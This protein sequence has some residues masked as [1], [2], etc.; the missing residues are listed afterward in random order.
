[1]A[2]KYDDRR[3][4]VKTWNVLMTFDVNKVRNDFPLLKKNE[5][6]VY[7]DNASTTQKP[8]IVLKAY[9]DYYTKYNANVHR[10]MYKI[11][12][13][14]TAEFELSRKIIAD[15][16]GAKSENSIIFTSGATASINTVVQG[17]GKRNL[18]SGDRVL[19][20][21]MEHH[22]NIVPWQML[23]SSLGIEIDYMPVDEEGQLDLSK[24]DNLITEKTK[25][26]SIIHQS[27][28]LGTVNPIKEIID[29]GHQRGC[30]VLIDGAQSIAHQ[31]IDVEE[32]GCDFFVFSGHKIYGPTGIGV[33]YGSMEKL[34]DMD[35]FMGGGEMISTVSKDGFIPNE[36]PWR[37]EAGTPAIA[38]VITLKVAIDYIK[39]IGI[40]NIAEYEND[41][42][43][44]TTTKILGIDG[45]ET[46]A[47][48][49]IDKGPVVSFNVKGVHPYDLTQI[50]DQMGVAIR[51]GHH[52][53]QPLMNIFGVEAMNRI[54]LSFYNTKDEIDYL[55]DS[56]KKSIAIIH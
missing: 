43:E 40:K 28:V 44:Y 29:K 6:L 54:S 51:S 37:F 42:L 30:V 50:L 5:K 39:S 21:E 8:D 16:I 19:L 3:C 35:P 41:L 36:I 45:I 53:A 22:S 27:N 32:L 24:I 49:D 38:E 56:I 4:E 12:E 52:C 47:C 33:L 48:G 10:G 26:I 20:T 13:E 9:Q 46:Y 23:K 34:E 1:M 14:A 15:R 2:S 25:L 7:L 18:E 31:E 55:V 11:A 17:W